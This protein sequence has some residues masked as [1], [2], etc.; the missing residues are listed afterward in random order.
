VLALAT[1]TPLFQGVGLRLL[2]SFWLMSVPAAMGAALVLAMGEIDLSLGAIASLS[3]VVLAALT[4]SGSLPPVLAVFIAVGIAFVIGCVNGALVAGLR[5]PSF[6]ATLGMGLMVAAVALLLARGQRILLPDVRGLGL[7]AGLLAVLAVLVL[8]A[9]T[10]V[11]AFAQQ[12]RLE[13][14]AALEALENEHATP[15]S[16]VVLVRGAAFALAATLAALAGLLEIARIRVAVP[17]GGMDR[18]LGAVAAALLGGALIYHGRGRTVLALAGAIGGALVLALART[19]L[20]M[21]AVEGGA[22]LVSAVAIVEAAA[23]SG[24]VRLI[25]WAVDRRSPDVSAVARAARA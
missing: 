2:A 14:R 11:L 16:G 3:G 10:V 12:G 15:G 18:G 20:D 1:H 9:L 23:L 6:L 5:L 19:V 25:E 13:R 17:V 24:T 7:I 8:G 4:V 22:Q 21:M